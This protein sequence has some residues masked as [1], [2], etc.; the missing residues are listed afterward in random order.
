MRA[1]DP[2]LCPVLVTPPSGKI[3]TV[4]SPVTPHDPP[5]AFPSQAVRNQPLLIEAHNINSGILCSGV[6]CLPGTV[7]I[8]Q[9]NTCIYHNSSNAVQFIDVYSHTDWMSQHL[10]ELFMVKYIDIIS[11]LV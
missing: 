1:E 9:I 4:D 8:C 3:H 6:L 2:S 10:D 7:H 5:P 11:N